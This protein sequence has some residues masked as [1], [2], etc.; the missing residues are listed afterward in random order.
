MIEK[1]SPPGEA[2]VP[3]FAPEQMH[4]PVTFD[5]LGNLVTLGQVL[6]PGDGPP[7]LPPDSLSPEQWLELTVKRIEGQPDF[8][9][10][11]LEGGFV[12]QRRAIQE[13]K[14]RTKVGRAVTEVQQLVVQD[15]M[16]RVNK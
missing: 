15:L 9:M 5:S 1:P 6:A 10:V 14:G 3:R 13:V 8:Q 2:R 12:D 7:P 4:L 16:N 11:M